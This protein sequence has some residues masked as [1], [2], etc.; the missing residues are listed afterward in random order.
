MLLP[1]DVRPEN[2]LYFNGAFIIKTIKANGAMRFM[3]LYLSTRERQDMPIALFVLAL[4]WLFLA[5][6]VRNSDGVI[7]LCS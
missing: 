5:S 6:I 7:E 3:D 1:K 2:C 4:D